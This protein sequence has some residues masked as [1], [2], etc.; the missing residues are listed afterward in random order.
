[1][2]KCGRSCSIV[3]EVETWAVLHTLMVAWN[4]GARKV[5]VEIDSMQAFKWVKGMEVVVNSHANVVHECQAW[6]KR[7]WITNVQ[8]IF[9]EGNQL[10]D[11]LAKLAIKLHHAYM[12]IWSSTQKTWR[13]SFSKMLWEPEVQE[14]SLSN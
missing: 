13:H 2:K 9:R 6:L 1:M 7:D 3:E 11:A 10:A 8:P 4:Y 12:K 14:E 5:I